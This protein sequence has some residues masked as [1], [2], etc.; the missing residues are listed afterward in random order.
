MR[1]AAGRERSRFMSLPIDAPK[2]EFVITPFG[3]ENSGVAGCIKAM[4][5]ESRRL[6]CDADVVPPRLGQD[7]P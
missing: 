5:N 2:R 3:R 6:G 1:A 7:P 4:P